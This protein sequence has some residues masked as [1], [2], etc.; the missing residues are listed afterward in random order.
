MSF[1]LISQRSAQYGSWG[2]LETMDQNTTAV[3]AP[4]YKAITE[5][6]TLFN[7]C[8][9][10]LSVSWQALDAR[11]DEKAIK[12]HWATAAESENEY[13]IIEKGS[14]NSSPDI[15]WQSIG[16][17]SGIGNSTT[18]RHY[19]FTDNQPHLSEVYYRIGQVGKDGKVTYSDVFADNSCCSIECTNKFISHFGFT[20]FAFITEWTLTSTVKTSTSVS[21]FSFTARV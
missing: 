19:S 10:P 3:P 13:Y 9:A 4:K 2:I 6:M 14:K 5:A 12:L 16:T 8:S 20:I 7:A 11:C 15:D 17:V 1:S 21:T 18:T